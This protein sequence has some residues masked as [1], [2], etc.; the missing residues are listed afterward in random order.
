MIASWLKLAYT[1]LVVQKDKT[2]H[3]LKYK[4]FKLFYKQFGL[5]LMKFIVKRMGGDTKAAEEVFSQTLLAAWKGWDTFESKSSYFTWVCKIGLHKIADYYRKEINYKSR[6]IAPLL[7]DFLQLED[8]SLS[9]EERLA[10][11]ELRSSVKECLNLMSDDKRQLLYLRYWKELS[12]KKIAEL[13]GIS[14]RS[15][16]GKL[17]RARLEFAQAYSENYSSFTSNY[18][19]KR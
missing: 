8:K 19:L 15:V 6:F 14:E 13:L 16:E 1:I 18:K 10:L 7:D 2:P 11:S 3:S 9:S 4:T 17:Y 5:P 12:H